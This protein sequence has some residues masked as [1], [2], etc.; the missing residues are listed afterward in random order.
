M[1][2]WIQSFSYQ[3]LVKVV[4]LFLVLQIGFTVMARLVPYRFGVQTTRSVACQF[5]LFKNRDFRVKRGH[6]VLF[7]V[8]EDFGPLGDVVGKLTLMKHVA[9]L[10]GDYVACAP[11]MGCRINGRAIPE[12]ALHLQTSMRITIGTIPP[13]LFAPLGETDRSYDFRFGGLA[14]LTDVQGVVIRCLISEEEHE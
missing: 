1:P 7:R 3:R 13:Y 14:S 5:F 9:G 4:F 8:P 11:F 10:P 2:R 6:L 12:P